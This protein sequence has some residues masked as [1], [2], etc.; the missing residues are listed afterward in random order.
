MQ[1][2]LQNAS[3]RIGKTQV[4]DDVSVVFPPGQITAIIG[5]NGAGK[6]SLLR[7]LAGHL[8]LDSGKLLYGGEEFSRENIEMRRSVMALFEPTNISQ[9]LDAPVLRAI[10][11]VVDAYDRAG[12]LDEKRFRA[13]TEE[14]ELTGKLQKS[15]ARLSRGEVY[16][17]SLAPLFLTG[18]KIL[19]IDE[20]FAAGLDQPGTESLRKWLREHATNG[21]TVVYTTQLPELV[22]GFA[23]LVVQIEGG[24]AALDPAS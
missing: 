12:D 11:E 20:P 9:R 19:L 6:T 7:A 16:R 18:C 14:F 10:L 24:E 3:R 4:L 17:T 2:E 1:I 21:G 15:T 13:F 23:D 22:E 8:V 5:R